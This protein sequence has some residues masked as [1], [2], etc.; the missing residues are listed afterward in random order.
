GDGLRVAVDHDRLVAVLQPQGGVHAGIVE[1][2][3][4]ADA[5]RAG[6]DDQHRGAIPGADLRLG[7][8]AGVVVGRACSEL[9]G[10]G[11]HRLVHRA[12]PVGVPQLAHRVLPETAD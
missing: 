3:A 5:V 8:V 11:V 7:V 4:L 12:Q 2:D 1:L 9:G 10:A 6:T